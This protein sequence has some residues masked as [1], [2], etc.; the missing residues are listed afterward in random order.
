MLMHATM[1]TE[2]EAFMGCVGEQVLGYARLH[3]VHVIGCPVVWYHK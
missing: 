1:G 3:F 2:V